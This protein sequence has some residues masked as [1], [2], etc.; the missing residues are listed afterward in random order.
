M[1]DGRDT[2]LADL[3]HQRLRAAM[4]TEAFDVEYAAGR[5]VSPEQI[6][7]LPRAEPG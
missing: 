3:D 1:S 4:G 5:T 7:D 2:E 6:V